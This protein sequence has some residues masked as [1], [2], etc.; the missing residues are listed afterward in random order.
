MKKGIL[1]TTLALASTLMFTGCS[2]TTTNLKNETKLILND[3]PKVLIKKVD[4]NINNEY[5][6]NQDLAKVLNDSMK[7]YIDI[8]DLPNSQYSMKIRIEK[9][10]I[11]TTYKTKENGETLKQPFYLNEV[12]TSVSIVLL[13]KKNDRVVFNETESLNKLFKAKYS[14]IDKKAIAMVLQTNLEQLLKEAKLSTIK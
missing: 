8:T 3:S 12:S 7:K 11:N 5:F 6:T 1:L 4:V 2:S 10:D 9:F 13:D 14:N